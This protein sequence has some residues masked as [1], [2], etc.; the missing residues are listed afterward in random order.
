G[1]SVASQIPTSARPPVI[2]QANQVTSA[3]QPVVV[4]QS[5]AISPVAGAASRTVAKVQGLPNSTFV[6]KP[7]KYLIETNPVL[8]ELKQFMS[9]DYLLAG[10]GYD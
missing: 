4:S 5:N 3:A 10:L 7:Q 9:S 2:A 1:T 6:S 8:T